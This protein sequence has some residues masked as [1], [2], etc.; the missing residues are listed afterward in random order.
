MINKPGR[1]DTL[2]SRPLVQPF[3]S[4]CQQLKNE[5]TSNWLER[6]WPSLK[7]YCKQSIN[8]SH[9]IVGWFTWRSNLTLDDNQESLA[10]ESFALHRV[11]GDWDRWLNLISVNIFRLFLTCWTIWPTKLGF[12]DRYFS[13][14]KNPVWSVFIRVNSI[15]SINMLIKL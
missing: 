4:V 7:C 12:F 9:W 3:L 5:S 14:N 1:V 6:K 10:P 15:K 11:W 13:W 8:Q 2:E